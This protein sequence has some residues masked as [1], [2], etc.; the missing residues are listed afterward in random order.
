MFKS[1]AISNRFLHLQKNVAKKFSKLYI[2]GLQPAGYSNVITRKQE[3]LCAATVLL[4]LKFNKGEQE[5]FIIW[6]PYS[7]RN[8]S[9][10]LAEREIE[11]GTR[12]SRASVFT[13]ISSPKL[14]QVLIL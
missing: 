4:P 6:F 2:G 11:V 1:R 10:S 13:L 5:N 8:T 9:G 14:S 7:Y 3:V 12:A